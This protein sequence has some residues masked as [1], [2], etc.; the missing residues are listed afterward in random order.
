[1]LTKVNLALKTFLGSRTFL[2]AIFLLMALQALWY[3]FA[4]EPGMRY[5]EWR[6][7]GVIEAYTQQISPW[8]GMQ[9][10]EHDWLGDITRDGSYL[11]YWLMSLLAR[12]VELFTDDYFTYVTV[13][14]STMIIIF[15]VGLWYFRKALLL[16]TDSKWLVNLALLLTVIMP[17][18]AIMPGVVNYDNAVFAVFGA[19][20][21]YALL[22]IKRR[23]TN[24]ATLI[25]FIAL[26]CLGSVMKTQFV[27]LYA[28]LLIYV[29]IVLW[30][31]HGKA[32]F[33]KLWQDLRRR[34]LLSQILLIALFIISAGIFIERPLYNT[35]V[36][37]K[38]APQSACERILSE[39][40]CLENHIAERNAF[41]REVN[42]QGKVLNPADYLVR[43]WTVRMLNSMQHEVLAY[44]PGD[45]QLSS[46]YFWTGFI[47]A[48]L[49]IVVNIRRLWGSSG[50][51]LLIITTVTYV[52]ILVVSN[53]M[54]YIQLGDT[55][56]V[57]GRYML[58]VLP[59]L[60]FL[61]LLSAREVVGAKAKAVILPLFA[62]TT[63][64]VLTQGAGI[65][66]T[67]AA[68]EESSY[69]DQ[70]KDVMLPVRDAINAVIV[71]D[72]PFT[73]RR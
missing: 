4:I 58:P 66:M 5:D 41:I 33:T 37:Q 43:V 54:L 36:Y 31:A 53:Y 63:L 2:L 9:D 70:T 71:D 18:A 27:A 29:A 26:G 19:S 12:L 39:E 67:A 13:L 3:I 17:T 46:A 59:I 23:K 48:G 20:L 56:A 8:I 73:N 28:P 1:M 10:T 32:V 62:V 49:V 15:A 22:L 30:Q 60:A 6:H 57:N 24:A 55:V 14:R 52:G 51:R 61:A 47:F 68:V 40:R 44:S 25:T 72:Q 42:E 11:F 21:Y 34:E 16:L 50:T 38:I 65:T 64:F 45:T 7:L 35:V 69:W